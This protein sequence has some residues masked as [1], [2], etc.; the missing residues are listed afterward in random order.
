MKTCECYLTPATEVK[1]YFCGTRFLI[2]SPA[3]C[4]ASIH[5]LVLID[6]GCR[7]SVPRI[8]NQR[9]R[10]RL[11]SPVATRQVVMKAV[12][13][14]FDSVEM[15]NSYFYIIAEIRLV[16]HEHSHLFR[17][18]FVEVCCR[19][20]PLCIWGDGTSSGRSISSSTN[21]FNQ[22]LATSE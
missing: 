22:T 7:R 21:A 1:K 20:T 18:L 13:V 2:I 11:L 16:Y 15:S 10:R 5:S 12:G 14:V 19:L 17:R 4:P 8:K 3:H 9:G 6:A